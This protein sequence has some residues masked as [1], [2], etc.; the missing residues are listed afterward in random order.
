MG[1]RVDKVQVVITVNRE[2]FGP[3]NISFEYAPD[4]PFGHDLDPLVAALLAKNKELI[5]V[6]IAQAGEAD[7]T[8]FL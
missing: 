3:I 8:V 7:P 1:F 5:D 4:K 2:W 6:K